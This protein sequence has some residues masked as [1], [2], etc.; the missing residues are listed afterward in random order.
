MEITATVDSG[1]IPRWEDHRH[2]STVERSLLAEVAVGRC[3]GHRMEISGDEA[4]SEE[5]GDQELGHPVM[6]CSAEEEVRSEGVGV[7]SAVIAAGVVAECGCNFNV[8]EAREKE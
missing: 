6:E 5:E 3:L 2:H 4:D 8:W 1:I 7:R